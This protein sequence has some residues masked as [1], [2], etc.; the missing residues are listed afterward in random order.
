MMGAGEPRVAPRERTW[1]RVMEGDGDETSRGLS[2]FREIPVADYQ[3]RE[4]GRIRCGLCPHACLMRDGE[5]GRCRVRLALDGRLLAEGYGVISSMALDPIEKKPLARY[6]PGTRVL[7]VGGYGCNLSC[8]FCQN[9]EISQRGVPRALER[10]STGYLSPAERGS[11]AGFHSAAGPVSP[12][13]L[14]D[15]ASSLAARGNIGLAFTY[16]EPFIN[17]EFAFDCAYLARERG[18]DVVLVTNG[19]VNLEP[20]MDILPLVSAMNIDLKAFTE[21]FYRSVCGGS[22]EPVKET[23]R[24]AHEACHVE[25]TTLVIPGLNSSASEI[26]ALASWIESVSPDIPLHLTRHHPSYRMR[27]PEPIGVDGLL[28]LA[29]VASSRLSTVIPGNIPLFS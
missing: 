19:F 2:P 29:R 11:S 1:A 27:E 18:L 20:L 5:R 3:S 8:S 6:K 13:D 12:S 10:G 25:L 17:H 16:N 26:E 14:V 15:E 24:L 9:H 4:G 23:I 22:L 28:S 7:S 21:G